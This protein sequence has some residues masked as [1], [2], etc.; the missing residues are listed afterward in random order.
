MKG[1]ILILAALVGLVVASDA[2]AFHGRQRV[3]VRQQRVV[4]QQV[5]VHAQPVVVQQVIAQPVYA[6]QF[7]APV[8]GQQ[9]V[10]PAVVA[11][12]CSAFFVK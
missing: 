12:G 10:A 3:V 7:V 9:F 2:Q 6:Q 11:P 5:R 8:Y 1:L 4:V